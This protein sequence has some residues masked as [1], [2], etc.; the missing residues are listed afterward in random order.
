MHDCFGKLLKPFDR[1]R[2]ATKEELEAQGHPE[3]SYPAGLSP[4]E[5]IVLPAYYG[6]DTCNVLVAPAIKATVGWPPNEH[7]EQSIAFATTG[8]VTTHTARALVKVEA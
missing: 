4:A 6:T 7:G 8:P 3:A 2:A 1:V 5:Q